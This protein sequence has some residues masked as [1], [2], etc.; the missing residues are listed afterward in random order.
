MTAQVGY[1]QG[2][3]LEL[4]RQPLDFC[5]LGTVPWLKFLNYFWMNN[6]SSCG[7]FLKR[8]TCFFF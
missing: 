6:M 1:G 4:G 3:L 5:V 2:A 8:L 7:L